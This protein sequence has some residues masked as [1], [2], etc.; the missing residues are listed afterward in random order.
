[1]YLPESMHKLMSEKQIKSY[2]HRNYLCLRES[3]ARCWEKQ[4]KMMPL[5]DSL[6]SVIC[7]LLLLFLSSNI[8]LF[9][10]EMILTLKLSCVS[11]NA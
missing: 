7:N 10:I 8:K 5:P 3:L 1:M 6:Q 2:A 11:V 9:I 4:C